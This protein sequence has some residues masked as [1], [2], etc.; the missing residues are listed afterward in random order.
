MKQPPKKKLKQALINFNRYPI[1]E[2][3]SLISTAAIPKQVA[4]DDPSS[5]SI[6]EEFN[7]G[8]TPT[9]LPST[10]D[11]DKPAPPAFMDIGHL[12]LKAK[13]HVL[14]DDDRETALNR[15]WVPKVIEDCPYS[16]HCAKGKP[17]RRYLN[18]YYMKRESQHNREWLAVSKVETVAGGWCVFCTMFKTHDY[19]GGKGAEFGGGGGQKMGALVST[20]LVNFK[21]LT[22]KDGVLDLHEKN[23]FH[24]RCELRV[25]EFQV[26]ASGTGTHLTAIDNIVDKHRQTEILQ[27]RSVIGALID[28]LLTLARQ[29]IP[30]RGHRDD[31][32]IAWTGEEPPE[33]DGNWRS[34][35]RLSIR[36][37]NQTL[38]E[39]LKMSKGNAMYC[40]KTIQNELLGTASTLIKEKVCSKVEQSRF[41]AVL[42]DETQDRAKREQMALVVRYVEKQ[43]QRWVVNEDPIAVVDV[44]SE[45]SNQM[46]SVD[47]N[48]NEDENSANDNY[49]PSLEDVK[50]SGKAIGSVIVS[51]IEKLKLKEVVVVGCGFDGAASMSSAKV[52]AAAVLKDQYPLADYFHC[53][54]HVLNLVASQAC[55]VTDIRHCQDIVGETVAFFNYSAK[56]TRCLKNVIKHRAPEVKRT[57]LVSLCSTRFIERH[58]AVLVYF[59]LLP[60]IVESLEGMKCWDAPDTRTGARQILSGILSTSFIISLVCMESVTAILRPVSVSLQKTDADLISVLQQVENVL[61]LFRKWRVEYDSTFSELYQRA[62]S[63]GEQMDVEF[64]SPRVPRRS[65]YRGNSG[66]NASSCEEYYRTNMYIPLLD[67]FISDLENRFGPHQKSSLNLATLVPS[68]LGMWDL[69]EPAVQKYI[70]HVDSLSAVKGEFHLWTQMW[71]KKEA[72]ERAECSTGNL[73]RVVVFSFVKVFICHNIKIK[74]SVVYLL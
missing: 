65:V 14:T 55:T 67:N 37:G 42:A 53:C 22:G 26:R 54:M 10:C 12:I 58:E 66:G 56:R 49:D 28:T 64:Q 69:L 59:D 20:P 13:S 72:A 41:M 9:T 68:H 39:H 38:A 46:K 45:I 71:E 11:V 73:L 47:R 6:N 33:N 74:L 44:L 50:L 57:K 30:L 60:Y 70:N 18:D 29:D 32:R 19:G 4:L 16:V 35:I 40:S 25:A 51:H 43:D 63:M 52:G 1:S 21:K 3:P 61:S 31:G 5:A 15:R 24:K 2:S 48:E 23:S 62:K 8:E 34:I 17:V 7:H 36:Q 27:N